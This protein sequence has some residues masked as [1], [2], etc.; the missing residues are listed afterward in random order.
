MGHDVIRVG[1][2]QIRYLVDGR[3]GQGLGVFEL[4]VPPGANVPPP[5][6]HTHNEEFVYGLEGSLRYSVD[7]ATRDL[8][9]G[10]WMSTPRGS[11]HGF[12]NEGTRPARALVVLTPDIGPQYFRDVGA[13]ID[14]GGPPDRARLAA[15]MAQ[16][17]L[18]PV[19]A[20]Q[21]VTA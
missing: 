1:Q 7:G 3:Q 20:P 14:A 16:Y 15:V 12:R 21:P 17:G 4:T 2:L 9:P 11:V 10:D 13:V 18:V 19:A 6:R 5:H 8:G